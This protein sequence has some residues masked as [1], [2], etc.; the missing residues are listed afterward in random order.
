VKLIVSTAVLALLTLGL[1]ATPPGVRLDEQTTQR[2]AEAD[3]RSPALHTFMRLGTELGSAKGVLLGLFLPAAF[4]TQ[5]A[6]AT[7]QTAFVASAG[8]QAAA[9]ALKWAT[10]RTRPDGESRRSNSSL[11]SAHAAAAA[12]IAWIVATRHRR[13]APWIWLVALWIAASRVFL[14]RHY[15]SD[16]LA[17]ALIGILCAAA[18]LQLRFWWRGTPGLR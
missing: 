18:A 1:L 12:G 7:A 3:R 15:P 10:N 11:P 5:V 17:G 9:T 6:R 13:L 14:G 2:A 8:D 4:G 16:V